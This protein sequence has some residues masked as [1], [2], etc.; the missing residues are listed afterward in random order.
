VA[1]LEAA[2][3]QQYDDEATH[4]Y[5]GR[6]LKKVENN[7]MLGGAQYAAGAWL[8]ATWGLTDIEFAIAAQTRAAFPAFH[9]PAGVAT[10]TCLHNGQGHGTR[11]IDPRGWHRFACRKTHGGKV[12]Q[13]NRV[14]S[15]ITKFANKAT[16]PGQGNVDVTHKPD[17][18]GL[19]YHVKPGYV[20][21]AG[22]QEACVRADVAVTTTSAAN[23]HSTIMID[24]TIRQ[25]DVDHDTSWQHGTGH[26]EGYWA[27]QAVYLAKWQMAK[28]DLY[29]FGMES[30]GRIGQRGMQAVDALAAIVHQAVKYDKT[31]P[32]R[33]RTFG[34]L[35]RTLL[36]DISVAFQRG[37]A[38]IMQIFRATCVPA[39]APVGVGAAA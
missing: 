13:H 12:Q 39:L 29:A 10:L 23:V 30:L 19:G 36:E 4:A 31:T 14:V 6:L 22:N 21:P 1:K 27:A 32:P 35:R 24:V 11:E 28:V 8:D 18:A 9:P 16:R 20:A 37:N 38:S 3:K 25:P 17:I 15:A 34:W 26:A 7:M 33:R 2:L 5:H